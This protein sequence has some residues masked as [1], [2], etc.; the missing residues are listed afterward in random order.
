M[1]N[2]LEKLKLFF[3]INTPSWIL[4][5]ILYNLPSLSSISLS[6]QGAND[7]EVNVNLI[8][9]QVTPLLLAMRPPYIL[10]TA[11]PDNPVITYYKHQKL[12]SL[13]T[14]FADSSLWRHWY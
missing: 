7:A 1:W 9:H 12:T 4:S 8:S 5:V 14:E 13:H 2:S 6:K 11:D 10:E 3:R